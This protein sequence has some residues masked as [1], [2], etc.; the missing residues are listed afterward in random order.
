MNVPMVFLLPEKVAY[1]GK[2][3]VFIFAFEA[4]TANQIAQFFIIEYLQNSVIV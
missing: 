4:L 2:I 1:S 3:W